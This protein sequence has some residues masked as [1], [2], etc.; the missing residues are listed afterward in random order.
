MGQELESYLAHLDKSNHEFENKA[1]MTY[2][3]CYIM[4]I[5]M[6]PSGFFFDSLV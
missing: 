5:N 3:L 2:A 4:L 1:L 6:T